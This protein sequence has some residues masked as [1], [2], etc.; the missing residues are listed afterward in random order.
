[1]HQDADQ[2]S[3]NSFNFDSNLRQNAWDKGFIVSDNPGEGDCMFHAL[4]EQLKIVKGIQ[5]SAAELRQQLVQYLQQN[6]KL[7]SN[8]NNNNSRALF[9]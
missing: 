4:S 2:R 1:M 6:P 5:L 9:I 7:V 3:V 8:I